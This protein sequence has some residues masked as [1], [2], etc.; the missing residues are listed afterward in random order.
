MWKLSGFFFAFV[1]LSLK[2]KGGSGIEWYSTPLTILS[3][4]VIEVSPSHETRQVKL[5]YKNRKSGSW[6][7]I[8]TG[9][10]PESA[11]GKLYF[12]LPMDL[13]RS[14]VRFSEK[15]SA[16][17]PFSFVQGRSSFTARKSDMTSSSI[18]R[19][20][21]MEDASL[22]SEEITAPAEGTDNVRESDLWRI[23]QNKLYYFNQFRGL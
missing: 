17:F 7:L 21:A 8:T 15:S 20:V 1:L 12:K 18:L 14:Q 19:S 2:T 11:E 22:S 9:H 10:L 16:T 4:Q 13:N 6:E 5:E 3:G 23:L